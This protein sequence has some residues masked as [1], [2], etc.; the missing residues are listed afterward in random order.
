[1]VLATTTR[2]SAK[3]EYAPDTDDLRG[4]LEIIN[5]PEAAQYCVDAFK[6]KME[7]L[8]AGLAEKGKAVLKRLEDYRDQLILADTLKNEPWAGQKNTGSDFQ[9][10]HANLSDKAAAEIV[11]KVKTPIKMDFAISEVSKL[12]R[13]FSAAGK[14]LS[15]ALTNALDKLVNAFFTQ[16]NMLTKESILV[17]CN[18]KGEIRRDSAGKPIVA[19]AE[20]VKQLLSDEKNGL[21]SFLKEKGIELNVQQHKFPAQKPAASPAV[22]QAKT[23]PS[24]EDA[25]KPT[26]RGPG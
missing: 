21:K 9:N 15:E 11:D 14:S 20:T 16:N 18:E 17:E 8:G 1:M 25:A 2:G 24:N 7:S 3:K 13:G 5:T 23:E 6:A 26:A 12:I 4:L 19:D 10:I 22:E